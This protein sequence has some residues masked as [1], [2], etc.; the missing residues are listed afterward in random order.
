MAL[1]IH[2]GS[3][4]HYELQAVQFFFVLLFHNLMIKQ[5]NSEGDPRIT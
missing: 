2:T 5:F 4:I 3:Q 1:T